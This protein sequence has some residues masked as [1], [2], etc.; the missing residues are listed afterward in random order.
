MIKNFIF[1]FGAVLYDIDYMLSSRAI[2]KLSNIPGSLEG[3]ELQEF[4]DVPSKYEKGEISS[5]EFRLYLRNEYQINCSDDEIDKAWNA[6]LLK[7]KPESPNFIK[8]L[9]NYGYNVVLLSNT[10]EIHYNFFEPECRDFFKLFDKTYFSY[11]IGMRK[12]DKEIYEFVCKDSNFKYNETIF[13]DDSKVNINSAELLG[14]IIFH[15]SNDKIL[16][17]ILHSVRI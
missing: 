4:I 5:A 17:D 8:E 15:Y 1:D 12:P 11:K 10:N 2:A 14:I 7:L 9:K 3:M 16:S 6:M 13:I